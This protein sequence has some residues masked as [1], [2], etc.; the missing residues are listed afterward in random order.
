VNV[1]VPDMSISSNAH[2]LGLPPGVVYQGSAPASPNAFVAVAPPPQTTATRDPNRRRVLGLVPAVAGSLHPLIVREAPRVKVNPAEVSRTK[3]AIRRAE[4]DQA[5]AEAVWAATT[6]AQNPHGDREKL[7]AA[8]DAAD[9]AARLRARLAELESSASSRPIRVQTVTVR[10]PSEV[11]D[12]L[13]S[14][15][16][17][18]VCMHDGCRHERYE[19]EEALRRHHPSA[20]EMA[21]LQ[22]TH[23]YALLSEAPLDPL[24]PDGEKVGYIACIGRDGTTVQKAIADAK[25]GDGFAEDVDAL[26]AENVSLTDRLAKLEAAIADMIAKGSKK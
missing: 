16:S 5:A 3:A 14:G 25:E 6:G 11:P 13:A 1:N 2:G 8:R 18:Y 7:L 23:V 20:T 24:D 21:R 12:A 19:S 22:Q 15:E 9:V 17:A 26:R 10:E 4:K